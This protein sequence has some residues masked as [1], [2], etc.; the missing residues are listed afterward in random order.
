MLAGQLDHEKKKKKKKR[1]AVKPGVVFLML[2]YIEMW[3]F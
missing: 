1:K 3:L 2:A